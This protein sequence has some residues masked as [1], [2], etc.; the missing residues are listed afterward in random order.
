MFFIM[1]ILFAVVVAACAIDPKKA[2]KFEDNSQLLTDE[3][4]PAKA[5]STADK[6][7][8]S[9]HQEAKEVE[10]LKTLPL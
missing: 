3:P 2:A 7:E 6:N 8:A 5:A 10:Q 1:I 4:T 9:A